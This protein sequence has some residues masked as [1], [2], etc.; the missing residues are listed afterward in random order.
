MGNWAGVFGSEVV[1]VPLVG[2]EVEPAGTPLTSRVYEAAAALQEEG[3]TATSMV[4]LVC[5]AP[6]AVLRLSELVP[7]VIEHPTGVRSGW[8]RYK[9]KSDPASPLSE[10]FASVPAVSV[11]W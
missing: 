3:L 4:L 6:N 7:R 10:I 2:V 11:S 9:S 5:V 8:K 1:V